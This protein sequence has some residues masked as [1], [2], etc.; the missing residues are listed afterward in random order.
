MAT[1]AKK[2]A[3]PDTLF[4]MA[5]HSSHILDMARKGAEH[6]FEELKAE[7]ATL[8]KN[9]PHL[10]GRARATVSRGAAALSRGGKAAVAAVADEVAPRKRRKM[11]AKARKAIGDAQRKRWAEQRAGAKK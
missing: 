3:D 2:L 4:I 7:I 6:K 8:V 11:S 1:P 9:F 10:A 5:K